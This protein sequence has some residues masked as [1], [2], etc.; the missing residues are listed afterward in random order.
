[1]QIQEQQQK[2]N[3]CNIPNDNIFMSITDDS[4]VP[5]INIHIGHPR[6]M[7]PVRTEGQQMK[8]VDY[9]RMNILNETNIT[10]TQ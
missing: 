8:T 9:N 10:N 2:Q 5:Y 4:H 6:K 7:Q 3:H 1:M